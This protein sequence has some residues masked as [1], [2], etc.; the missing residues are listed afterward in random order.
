MENNQNAIEL[1]LSF[2]SKLKLYLRFLKNPY[3]SVSLIFAIWMLFFDNNS[4]ML[5]FELNGK[6]NTL[7]GGLKYYERELQNDKSKLEQLKSDP[8][9][10]EKFAREA[11]LMCKENE[12]VFVFE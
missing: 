12:E 4:L 2:K 5:H 10:L 6:I 1:S 8:Y 7:K 9:K 11:Y 3:I